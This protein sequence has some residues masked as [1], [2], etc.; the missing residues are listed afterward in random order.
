MKLEIGDEI[1]CIKKKL[2]LDIMTKTVKKI[3]I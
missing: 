3:V 2:H 1:I